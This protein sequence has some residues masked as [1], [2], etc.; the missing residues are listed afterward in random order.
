[1]DHFETLPLYG[2]PH[3]AACSSTVDGW[4]DGCIP[5]DMVVIEMQL[6]LL[7]VPSETSNQA[8]KGCRDSW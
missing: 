3:F 2:S 6:A 8:P 4:L 1:M 5:R 7:P